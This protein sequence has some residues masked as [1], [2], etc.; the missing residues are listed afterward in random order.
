MAKDYTADILVR[1]SQAAAELLAELRT[2]DDDLAHDMVEGETDFL[3]AL[4]AAV[5]EI[6]ACEIVV[7]GCKVKED[8]IG[9]RRRR[10]EDRAARVRALIEQ[11]M[12]TVDLPSVR[13][14]TATLT[15]KA[16]PPKPI[17]ADESAIPA[18]FW[19][20]QPPKLD[21]RALNAAAKDRQIPGV[22]M[23]NGSVALQIRRG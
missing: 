21:K 16:V 5:D 14:P 13:L 15:V 12:L 20:A 3:E 6:D 23:T 1:Q 2:D 11:A 8:E 4:G 18:E 9:K 17:I 7:A 10:A 22:E 19:E